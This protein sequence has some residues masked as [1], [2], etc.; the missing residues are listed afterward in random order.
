M[1]YK[2]HLR[3]AHAAWKRVVKPGETVIDATCGNGHD[4][5]LLAQLALNETAGKVIAIDIQETA[6]E[7]TK[8]RLKNHLPFSQFNRIQ[9][10]SEGHQRFPEIKPGSIKLIV[11][12]LGYLPGS[13]KKLTTRA[14]TTLAS[15]Q[16]ASQLIMPGGM[17]CVTCYPGHPE[18][19]IE[20]KAVIQHIEQWSLSSWTCTILANKSHERSPFVCTSIRL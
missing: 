13:D 16:H 18:G 9:F 7:K 3:I 4:T 11:Y 17:I 5:L 2:H 1:T 12:N 15:L 19:L 8:E 14:D 6:I 10:S 20:G